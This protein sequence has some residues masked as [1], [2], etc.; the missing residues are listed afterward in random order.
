VD[1]KLES[2]SDVKKLQQSNP[3]RANHLG[4]GKKRRTDSVRYN[5]KGKETW[6]EGE[7]RNITEQGQESCWTSIRIRTFLRASMRQNSVTGEAS[8]A[9]W[10]GWKQKRPRHLSKGKGSVVS[11]GALHGFVSRRERRQESGGNEK[12]GHK[13]A[14]RRSIGREEKF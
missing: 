14:W 2:T 7:A 8:A 5:P 3:R 1:K 4:G 6:R 12:R 9:S 13:E 10:G 11:T